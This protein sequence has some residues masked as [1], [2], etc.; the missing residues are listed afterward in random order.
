[1]LQWVCC[2]CRMKHVT[3]GRSI[4]YQN[5]CYVYYETCYNASMMF[6]EST[7]VAYVWLCLWWQWCWILFLRLELWIRKSTMRG[8]KWSCPLHGTDAL[9]SSASQ[10]PM[11]TAAAWRCD[12][13]TCE[14]RPP[15]VAP[16]ATW[17]HWPRPAT[18]L[19]VERMNLLLPWHSRVSLCIAFCVCISRFFCISKLIKSRSQ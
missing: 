17:P 9:P 4:E 2:Q 12:L 19:V 11:M 18:D 6:F 8:S 16:Q 3:V 5:S 10:A 14:G 13:Q 7:S 1:M 15:S